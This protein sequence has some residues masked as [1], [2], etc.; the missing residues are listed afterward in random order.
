MHAESARSRTDASRALPVPLKAD[1]GPLGA[2]DQPAH[3]L[4]IQIAGAL[5]A[6]QITI[7]VGLGVSTLAKLRV[8]NRGRQ[9][10]ARPL[11][12]SPLPETR[13]GRPS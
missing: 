7:A 2:R 6:R 4:A 3:A 10:P 8:P 1:I 5:T 11:R 9:T 12:D 13:C